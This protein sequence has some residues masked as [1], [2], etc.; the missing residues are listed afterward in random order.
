MA[1]SNFRQIRQ[2]SIEKMDL[3]LLK[4]FV[5]VAKHRSISKAGSEVYLTQ[6]AVTKQIQSL[7]KMYGKSLFERTRKELTLT[8]DGKL[9][10]DYANRMLSLLDESFAMLERSGQEI[11]GKL[12][13]A[14]NLTLGVY[15]I[16]K[17]LRF[18]RDV[19]P[20]I[21]IE[22]LLGQLGEHH[23]CDQEA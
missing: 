17:I 23:H 19:Y 20:Q 6:P 2:G 16:P 15:I 13:I 3:C 21:T 1:Y 14:S 9:L 4:T 12:K 11:S 5:T 18:F 10:L 7:E 8:E 22:V